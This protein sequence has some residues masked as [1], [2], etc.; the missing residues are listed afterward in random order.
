MH[1]VI[2]CIFVFLLSTESNLAQNL[3]KDSH[4]ENKICGDSIGGFGILHLDDWFPSPF[5]D[6]SV[7]I[8]DPFTRHLTI[9]DKSDCLVPHLRAG[10]DTFGVEVCS[11]GDT[12]LHVIRKIPNPISKGAI[13]GLFLMDKLSDSLVS[14]N[15]NPTCSNNQVFRQN[16]FQDRKTFK[17]FITTKL[18]E[19]L[20][21]N[22]EYYVE[23]FAIAN[24]HVLSEESWYYLA[25]IGAY[26]SSDTFYNEDYRSANFQAHLEHNEI[27]RREDGWV[28][29]SGTFKST[30]NEKFLTIGH[31]REFNQTL[32]QLKPVTDFQERHRLMAIDYYIDAVYLFDPQDTV[33]AVNLPP[34]TVL[35][36]GDEMRLHARHDD[37]FKLEDTVKT[38]LWST[39]ATDSSITV[40]QPGTY[41]VRVT[42]NHRFW[43]ADTIVIDSL[44]SYHSELPDSLLACLDDDPPRLEAAFPPPHYQL[45]WSNGSSQPSIFAPDSGL[46]V[47]RATGPCDTLRDSV[48]VRFEDCSVE[49]PKPEFIIPNAFSPNGDGLNDTWFIPDLPENTQVLIF[50]RWGSLLYQSADYQGDWDGTNP[51]G[52]AL[53]TGTYTYRLTYTY[54]PGI[55]VNEYGTVHIIR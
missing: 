4:F 36:A 21:Q 12:A 20:I 37:G 42:Y 9:H 15:Y 34:D 27:I 19:P 6:S 54:Y 46:Y 51:R 8:T 23:F 50:D 48:W 43:A 10:Y 39:G 13:I 47:L 14:I 24:P 25:H 53:P 38:F 11:N 3:I 1:R 5:R 55:T 52:E 40:T 18:K 22:K 17:T 26:A 29:V 31:F 28:K 7:I 45:R 32:Y 16:P 41:W 44:E 33:F 49:D 2:I 30:G 35:C